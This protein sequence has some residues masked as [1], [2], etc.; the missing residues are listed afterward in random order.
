MGA[1]RGVRRE[2]EQILEIVG[3]VPVDDFGVAL[4]TFED[5][6]LEEHLEAAP[7]E[8][9]MMVPIGQALEGGDAA[10]QLRRQLHLLHGGEQVVVGGEGG[11][12][13]LG[14]HRGA[15]CSPGGLLVEL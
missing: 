4:R 7:N 15:E 1:R 13:V 2:V 8:A 12:I 9:F 6:L 11:G 3:G 5:G 14:G 10:R